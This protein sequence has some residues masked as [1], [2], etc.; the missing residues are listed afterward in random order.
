MDHNR[1]A[2]P[3]SSHSPAP[4][5]YLPGMQRPPS[6]PLSAGSLTRPPLAN[7]QTS[8]SQPSMPLR[9]PANRG[10]A[11][12]ETYTLPDAIDATI[13][14]EIRSRFERDE[15]GHVL[16]FTAPPLHLVETETLG[17]SLQYTAAKIRARNEVAKRRAEIESARARY[18]AEKRERLGAEQ[19]RRKEVEKD[20][21]DRVVALVQERLL[22]ALSADL[23]AL[24][25]PVDRLS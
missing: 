11:P 4:Q 5:G 17:H 20:V 15:A 8:Y 7:V 21:S 6:T 24:D 13:P 18:R 25:A 22:D 16:F 9:D 14:D 2:A 1:P 19:R 23:V 3:H 10:P 12:I